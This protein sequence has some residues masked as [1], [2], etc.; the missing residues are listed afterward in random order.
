MRQQ[1]SLMFTYVC[2]FK[3]MNNKPKHNVVIL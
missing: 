3:V 2:I 1:K